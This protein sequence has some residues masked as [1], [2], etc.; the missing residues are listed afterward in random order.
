MAM[1]KITT[2]FITFGL[3][4][5]A[6]C[7]NNFNWNNP[8]DPDNSMVITP[9]NIF[10]ANNSEMVPTVFDLKWHGGDPDPGDTVIYHVYLDTIQPPSALVYAGQDTLCPV[11]LEDS[12]MYYWYICATDNHGVESKSNIFSFRTKY[13]SPPAVP[14]NPLPACGDTLYKVWV[15]YSKIYWTSPD[16]DTEDHVT[17][18]IY[19]DTLNP[20]TKLYDTTNETACSFDGTLNK[21]YYWYI[22]AVDEHGAVAVGEVWYFYFMRSQ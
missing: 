15:Y 19:A 8:L 7:S 1:N 22:R 13:N 5:A 20:P 4:V 11:I 14:S 3:L 18:E 9:T 10:P 2:T 12:K 6:G 16:P 17:Y 21:T